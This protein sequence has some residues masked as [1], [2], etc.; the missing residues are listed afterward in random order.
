MSTEPLE[1]TQEPAHAQ[2]HSGSALTLV[3]GTEAQVGALVL[4][5]QAPTT[6]PGGGTTYSSDPDSSNA[7]PALGV[8]QARDTEGR[9][10]TGTVIVAAPDGEQRVMRPQ[11]HGG[12]LVT[13]GRKGGGSYADEVR[14]FSREQ[15]LD[16]LPVLIQKAKDNQLRHRDHIKLAELL[17]RIGVPSQSETLDLEEGR[18][19]LQLV[20]GSLIDSAR[21]YGVP[22]GVVKGWYERAV[23]EMEAD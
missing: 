12:A 15:V 20:V 13:G 11:P 10:S 1:A 6:L 8:E 3:T 16:M 23:A 9:F 21:S 17:A 18:R 22:D 19:R 14:R 7:V 4:D 5:P 2:E